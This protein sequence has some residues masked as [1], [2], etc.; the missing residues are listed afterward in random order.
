MAKNFEDM[1]T[2]EQVVDT[3]RKMNMTLMNIKQE[4]SSLRTAY[5]EIEKHKLDNK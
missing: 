4:I 5:E 2:Q 1:N 3:L